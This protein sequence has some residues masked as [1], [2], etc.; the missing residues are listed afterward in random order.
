MA[1]AVLRLMQERVHHAVDPRRALLA[2]E[3]LTCVPEAVGIL[4]VE[5]V[6]LR[7]VPETEKVMKNLVTKLR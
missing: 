5:Q 2:V 3:T 6:L 7:Q 4:L 1:D